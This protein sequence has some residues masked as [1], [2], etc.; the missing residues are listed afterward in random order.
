MAGYSGTPLTKKLGIV[1]GTRFA[2]KSAPADFMADLGELPI[3]AEQLARVR[4]PV[5]VVVAFFTTRA[6]GRSRNRSPSRAACSRPRSV[7]CMP[8]SRPARTPSPLALEWP[9]RTSR[10]VGTCALYGAA[11]KCRHGR[12]GR[13]GVAP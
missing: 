8:G 9:W 11:P 10:T 5:D 6:T 13:G 2:L 1:E 3:G 7:R 4:P 12:R